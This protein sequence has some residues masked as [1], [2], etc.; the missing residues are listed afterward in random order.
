M[1][2]GL[3]G[4]SGR[5]WLPKISPEACRQVPSTG[6]GGGGRVGSVLLPHMRKISQPLLEAVFKKDFLAVALNTRFR[7]IFIPPSTN[8]RG[9]STDSNEGCLGELVRF[10]MEPGVGEKNESASG[11]AVLWLWHG[12]YI[13][14]HELWCNSVARATLASWLPMTPGERREDRTMSLTGWPQGP[15]LYGAETMVDPRDPLT[16]G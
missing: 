4:S 11:I 7:E 2:G 10:W 12:K 1:S 15:G 3:I 9:I 5:P 8:L 13:R 14:L 16:L 6:G